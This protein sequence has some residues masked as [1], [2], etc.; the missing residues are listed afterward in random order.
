M[1]DKLGENGRL[2]VQRN[3]FSYGTIA[4]NLLP[5]PI[6][7]SESKSGGNEHPALPLQSNLRLAVYFELNS[8]D[9]LFFWGIRIRSR[10]GSSKSSQNV[11]TMH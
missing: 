7:Y 11:T 3:C 8:T 9:L 1:V 2:V 6:S 4:I 5:K 10:A